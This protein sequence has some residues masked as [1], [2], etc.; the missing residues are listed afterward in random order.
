MCMVLMGYKK[1]VES[2]PE[3]IRAQI[4]EQHFLERLVH[5][6]SKYF[7]KLIDVPVIYTM[8]HSF[9]TGDLN[10]LVFLLGTQLLH[11][12]GSWHDLM[13]KK[14]TKILLRP[15]LG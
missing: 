4:N 2:S 15:T 8:S 5:L 12:N 14:R 13:S 9:A 7:T 10:C 1:V 11:N 3:T 6:H